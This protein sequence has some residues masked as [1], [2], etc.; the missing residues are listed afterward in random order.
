[1]L[2]VVINDTNAREE[3]V[4]DLDALVVQGARRMLAV[5]LQAEAAAYIAAHTGELDERGHR[6]VVR[7]GHARARE[8]L[9]GAGPVPVAVPRVADRRTDPATGAK[10]T[11]PKLMAEWY[12]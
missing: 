8:I 2:S 3:L 5:A 10:R 12:G 9:T 1:M 7:N 11:F 4:L 6:L